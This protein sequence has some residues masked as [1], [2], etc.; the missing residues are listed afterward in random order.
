VLIEM[1]GKRRELRFHHFSEVPQ[2]GAHERPE[3]LAAS[4]QVP[5][6]WQAVALAA[7]RFDFRPRCRRFNPQTQ[8][9]FVSRRSRTPRG[10]LIKLPSC[11][12]G[13]ASAGCFRI[14]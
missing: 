4:S 6:E 3:H 8:F 9:L 12:T 14:T 11:V 10:A 2:A 7:G 1:N 13:D 5:S